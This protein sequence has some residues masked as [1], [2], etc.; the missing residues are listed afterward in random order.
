MVLAG[1][2]LPWIEFYGLQSGF[3]ALRF[4]IISFGESQRFSG[5]SLFF[6]FAFIPVTSIACV[7]IILGSYYTPKAWSLLFLSLLDGSAV[8][9]GY[10]AGSYGGASNL[11]VW[12]Y[13]MI[14]GII[15]LN[16]QMISKYFIKEKALIT[17]Q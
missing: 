3:S 15:I 7:W 11:F 8:F 17:P 14:C 12:F 10:A 6:F 16:V 13:M 5:F 2:C 9:E 1:F 4:A